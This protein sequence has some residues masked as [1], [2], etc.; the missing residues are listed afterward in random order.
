MEYRRKKDSCCSSAEKESFASGKKTFVKSYP[1]KVPSWLAS[2][3]RVFSTCQVSNLRVFLKQRLWRYHAS[4]SSITFALI[5][6]IGQNFIFRAAVRRRE[7]HDVGSRRRCYHWMG[8]G[9]RCLQRAVEAAWLERRLCL[10]V[11]LQGT[12]SWASNNLP[13][14]CRRCNA[15][16]LRLNMS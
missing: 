12:S 3:S 7:D 1:E 9:S 16:S 15:A 13:C 6:S 8:S 5:Y 10:L 14:F 4:M 11:F 2:C